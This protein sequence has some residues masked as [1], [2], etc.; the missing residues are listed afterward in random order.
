MVVLAM[1]SGLS[2]VWLYRT[3]NSGIT[4]DDVTDQLTDRP[5]TVEVEGPQEPLNILVMGIDARDCSGCDIDNETGADGSDN[6]MLIHLSADRTRA[7][8]V[9]IPRDSMVDRPACKT[10]D[11]TTIPAADYQMWNAAFSVGGAACTIQQFES[12]TDIRIDH[13][14]V[15]DFGSFKDMVDAVGGVEMCIPEDI[16]DA[17]HGIHIAAGTRVLDGDE[18]LEYVRERYAVSQGSDLGRMKRQQ[19]FLASLASTVVSANTLANPVRLTKFLKAATASLT[20]D[21]GL[22][23]I[24]KLAEL[25]YQFRNISLDGIQFITIPNTTD[26]NDY[27][28]LVWTDDAAKVWRKLR[29]DKPLTSSIATD[30]ISAGNLPGSDSSSSSS[31]S[32]SPSASASS[33]TGKKNK[34]KNSN[35]GGAGLAD[36]EQLAAAGLCT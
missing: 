13:Y 19:A 36:D 32:S 2:L 29:N 16:D 21:S 33:G 22:G 6:T 18:A 12:L 31:A 27:N 10:E 30:A 17:S 34:K 23:S 35:T 14:V 8:G 4:V 9:S 3:L 1:V 15:V 7:Y 28:R 26:P 20:V 11:G 24:T 25:G 5:T